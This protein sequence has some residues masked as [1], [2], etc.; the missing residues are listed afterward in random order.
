MTPIRWL[1]L[2]LGLLILCSLLAVRAQTIFPNEVSQGGLSG[3]GGQFT[4]PANLTDDT[5]A[6]LLTDDSGANQLVAQ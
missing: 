5:G 3:G 2:A 1:L 6:N 4:P